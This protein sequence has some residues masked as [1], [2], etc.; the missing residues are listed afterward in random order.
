M[1]CLHH[2]IGLLYARP[3][4]PESLRAYQ[5]RG[6]ALDFQTFKYYPNRKSERSGTVAQ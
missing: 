2:A 3:T 4:Q 5:F 1:T 6:K